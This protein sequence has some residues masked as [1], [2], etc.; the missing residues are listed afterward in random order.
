MAA[1]YILKQIEKEAM[2]LEALKREMEIAKS[3]DRKIRKA[4]KSV[5]EKTR[6]ITR[7]IKG[8][9]RFSANERNDIVRDIVKEC[10][11]DGETLFL[12]L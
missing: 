11:W 10:T 1:K 12:H 3:E 2:N 8:L 5:N 4:E 9:D 6:E 7:L